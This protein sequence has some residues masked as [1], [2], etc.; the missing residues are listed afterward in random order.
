MS[1]TANADV[2]KLF[3]GRREIV[4]Y[5]CKRAYYKGKIKQY[6]SHTYSRYSLRKSEDIIPEIKEEVGND[7]VI[8]F[9]AFVD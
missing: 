1:A 4:S 3:M 8:T 6:I 9:M 5:Q 7:T 2:Y